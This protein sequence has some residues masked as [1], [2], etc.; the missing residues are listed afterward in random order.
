MRVRCEMTARNSIDP[1]REVVLE[2][3]SIRMTTKCLSR[4]R[5][6][7][8]VHFEFMRFLGSVFFMGIR[9]F[10]GRRRASYGVMRL[11]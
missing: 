8:S 11:R 4:W 9:R 5:G 7:R 6:A 10:D 3:A 1:A 2:S